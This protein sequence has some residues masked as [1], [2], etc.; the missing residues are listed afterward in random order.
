MFKLFKDLTRPPERL[1]QPSPAPQTPPVSAPSSLG[2]TAR[3][4]TRP[5]IQPTDGAAP[6][7]PGETS[8]NGNGNGT[9]APVVAEVEETDEDAK[10][11]VEYLKG[12][13]GAE[14]VMTVVEVSTDS[15]RHPGETELIR[16]ATLAVDLHQAQARGSQVFPSTSRILDCHQYPRPEIGME[17]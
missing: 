2:Y 15:W 4:R 8:K 7:G 16:L 10:K 12:L 5:P 11:V 9:T 6:S 3:Q 1:D 17:A 14:T 13:E